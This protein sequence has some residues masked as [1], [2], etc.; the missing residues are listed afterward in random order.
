MAKPM[1][2]S[3]DEDRPDELHPF[4]MSGVRPTGRRLGT[5]Y[6]GIVEELEM[7]GT[8]YAGKKLRQMFIGSLSTHFTTC[9][10]CKTT[11]NQEFRQLF[12]LRHP[13]VIQFMGVCFFPRYPFPVLVMEQMQHNLQYVLEKRTNIAL[14]I[15]VSILQDVARGLVYLHSRSQPIIH[16]NLN[17]KNI[18]LSPDMKAK[19]AGFGV[20]QLIDTPPRKLAVDT[21]SIG[22]MAHTPPEPCNQHPVPSMDMFSFGHLS[23]FVAIQVCPNDLLS[24]TY[25]DSITNQVKGRLEFERRRK[26]VSRLCSNFHVKHPLVLLVRKC[27]DNRPGERPTASQALNSLEEMKKVSYHMQEKQLVTEQALRRHEMLG[28]SIY[29]QYPFHGFRLQRSMGKQKVQPQQSSHREVLFRVLKPFT[30]NVRETGEILGQGAH[31]TVVEVRMGQKKLAAKSFREICGTDGSR[32]VHAFSHKMVLLLQLNHPNIVRYEGICFM[33]NEQQIPTLLMERMTYNLHS[34]LLQPGNKVSIGQKASILRDVADGLSYLHSQTPAII[35]RDLTATNILLNC[36]LT[37]KI[38]DFGNTRIIDLNPMATPQTM[39]ANPGTI[40]YMPPEA[41]EKSSEHSDKLDIFSFGHLLLFTIVQEP[42]SL[43][44]ATYCSGDDVNGRSEVERR[45][46][47]VSKAEQ[48]LGI[49]FTLVVM[50][51]KCLDLNVEKRPTAKKIF[52]TLDKLANTLQ[53]KVLGK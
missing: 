34:Y 10:S 36:Q 12:E 50:M 26:Y 3:K 37:A 39:T 29:S 11:M 4:I 15:R 13:H 46:Q 22:T 45:Q 41:C 8:T 20:S 27:L 14:S 17:A 7:D 31:G 52:I 38:A 53:D 25:F 35:H 19:I 5:G 49:T 48:M 6:F 32:F 21:S 1:S 24:P 47:F 51:K 33:S 42:I 2:L 40:N 28:D 43:L 44:P 9:A 23:L 16:R 18:L 30:K